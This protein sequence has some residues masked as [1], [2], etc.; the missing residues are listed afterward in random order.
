MKEVLELREKTGCSLSLCK[1]A[2]EYCK[3]KEDVVPIG[4]LKAK[5]LAVYTKM[6][7]EDRVKLF[8]RSEIE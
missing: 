7:F 8:S 5:T 3:N 4:Y 1:E 2:I 6:S